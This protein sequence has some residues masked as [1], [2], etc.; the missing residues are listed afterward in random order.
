MG[1]RGK[2][3]VRG[4]LVV[5]RSKLAPMRTRRTHLAGRSRR[6][7]SSWARHAPGFTFRWSSEMAKGLRRTAWT[8]VAVALV[9]AAWGCALS[10]EAIPT[11]TPAPPPTRPPS[12]P[13]RS[14]SVVDRTSHSL[15]VTWSSSVRARSY[16]LQRSPSERRDYSIVASGIAATK[17]V[18]QGLEPDSVYYYTVRA[19]NHLGCSGLAGDEVGGVTESAGAVDIPRVP[20]AVKVVKKEVFGPDIDAVTWAGVRGATYY[21]VFRAGELLNEISAPRNRSSHTDMGRSFGVSFSKRYQVRACNKA[22]CSAL[23]GS[24]RTAGGSGPSLP[25]RIVGACEADLKLSPGEG[26]EL[27]DG[28]ADLYIEAEAELGIHNICLRRREIVRCSS[29]LVEI[30]KDLVAVELESGKEWV[31]RHH[32]LR[33]GPAAQS[34]ARDSD[35]VRAATQSPTPRRSPER[36]VQQ[37]GSDP[38]RE[39]FEASKR[40]GYTRI[41]L[42]DRG[43]V[44]GIPERFTT[45]S[46]LGAVAYML[47]GSVKGCDFANAELDRSGI[48]YAKMEPL[49]RLSSYKAK[50]GCRKTSDDWEHGLERPEDHASAVLR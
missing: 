34:Q 26:C 46:S 19:C 27:E 50:K 9:V 24:M 28:R 14:I 10:E 8:G 40:S 13:P 1:R 36:S 15:T 18:D 4:C 41:P 17:F 45:D 11:P 35:A 32:P 30:S 42:T 6:T 29:Y 23:S 47:L 37:T 3:H 16:E 22:G 7:V 25:V 49:G 33:T 38:A 5:T 12:S 44:W 20:S 21:E 31:I 43:T 39:T 2:L 48:V